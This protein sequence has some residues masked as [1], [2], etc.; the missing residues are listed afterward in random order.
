[1]KPEP[2]VLEG[3]HVR[4]APLGQEHCAA[5]CGI[6]LDADIWRWFPDPVE[7]AD[8][9]REWIDQAIRDTT[10][11]LAVPFVIQLRDGTTA[12]ST[13]YGN[14][15][16]ANRR[17]EIGWTWVAPA[18]QRSAVNTEAKLLLLA[19]AFEVLQ[20]NR[21]EFKTDALNT[22]SRK[23]LAGIGATEEGVLRRHMVTAS[24]RLRDS[25]YF[26]VIREEWPGVRSGLEQRLASHGRA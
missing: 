21:V 10:A 25:V 13:R 17:L 14:I 3:S 8:Q 26:S 18:H 5:L 23:A 9:M 1:M 16:H 7:T 2:V 6:G 20:Y 24:G 4:L 12:G 22:K 15:N 11:G 19:H